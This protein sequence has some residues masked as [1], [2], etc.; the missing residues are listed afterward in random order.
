MQQTK[1]RAIVLE[2]KVSLYCR[3]E[4][5]LTICTQVSQLERDLRAAEERYSIVNENK[6]AL[7]EQLDGL[8]IQKGSLENLLEKEKNAKHTFQQGFCLYVCFHLYIFKHSRAGPT[9]TRIPTES[10]GFK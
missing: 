9:I 2:A 5:L 8:R 6:M 3:V 7:E 4:L 10:T 1:E